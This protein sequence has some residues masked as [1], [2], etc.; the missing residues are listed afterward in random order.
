[1]APYYRKFHTFNPPSKDT[2]EALA[3]DYID[4]EITGK[5]GPIQASFPEFHGSLGKAWP[6]T[7]KNLDFA[8]TTDP[9]SGTSTGGFSYLSSVDPKTWERSHA[10]SAYY[11][12]I[13]DRSNLHLL[14]NSLVEKI[15]LDKSES[16]VIATGVQFTRNG[17]SEIRN[18]RK[19]VLLCAGVFQ[20]PQLLELSGIGSPK[21]LQ[22]HGIDIVMENTN[23]GENLQDHPMSGMS[24]EVIDGL[25]TIDMIRDPAV[26]QGAMEAYQSSRAGPL[27]SCYHSVASL[28]VIEFLSEKGKTELIELL[29][30][31]TLT[32]SPSQGPSQKM[33]Y[34]ILRSILESPSDGSIII[35]MGASQ[36]HFNASLQKDIYAI[37]DPGN[38]LSFL[39]A[40]AHPYSRG[41]VHI[42]SASPADPPK[43]DPRYLSHPLD[44]EIL[45][46]HMRYIPTIAKTQPL[47]SLIKDGGKRLP[48][49]MDIS[50]LEAAKEHIKRNLITNNHPC[51][52][53]AMLPRDKGGVV[54]EKL[55]V[56][57]VRNLRI[58]D[59]SVFP[60]IPRGNIQSSVYAVAE[61]AA[62]LIMEG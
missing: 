29:D 12:P 48:E 39:V 45:A 35:G 11:A 55:R 42:A 62:D 18:A 44:Q 16:D 4:Q 52:T 57:G 54:D 10:G 14:T 15:I 20:S 27:T 1:M 61:R 46:R 43:I 23:V 22:S 49:G 26:I 32:P 5:S 47:A 3:T 28:P 30:T 41:T 53:C 56:H 7:F 31:Y 2:E 60:M 38:Y 36:I 19:E 37:T 8:M 17:R 40:L 9:L 34:D 25:P 6:E 24:F 59:A 33:Q 50:T 13:A 58:V 51:G 21:L